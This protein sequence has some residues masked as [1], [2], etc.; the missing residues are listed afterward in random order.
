M[1]ILDSSY[2]PVVGICTALRIRALCSTVITSP[3]FA[4]HLSGGF[5]GREGRRRIRQRDVR[6]V[7]Y[8]LKQCSLVSYAS[9]DNCYELA[10][11]NMLD[12]SK[13]PLSDLYM[14]Q[15]LQDRI[16]RALV[17]GGTPRSAILTP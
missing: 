15:T 14:E 13:R 11:R 4:I 17:A 6:F 3:C 10:S 12:T 8:L 9:P 1:E 16:R 7:C 5:A 2:R